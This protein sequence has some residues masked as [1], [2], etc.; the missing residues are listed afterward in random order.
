[1]IAEAMEKFKDMIQPSH[2]EIDGKNYR[3]NGYRPVDDGN[4]ESLGTCTLTSIV[5]YFNHNIDKLNTKKIYIHAASHGR[6]TLNGFVEGP[7]KIRPIFVESLALTNSFVFGNR[8]NYEQFIIALYSQFKPTEDR[9]YIAN[10]I[11]NLTSEASKTLKDNGMTQNVHAKA[12]ISM[13]EEVQ[14][15]NPVKLRPF[16]T[17]PEIEQPES[18]FVFRMEQSGDSIAFSLHEC[19]GS[20]WKLEAIQSIRAYFKDKLPDVPVIA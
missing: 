16:R 18:E 9:D 17:F 4:P 7:F 2:I 11:S 19:D 8:Y 12:G 6:V 10:L 13:K 20:A 15:K 5:D 3:L 1:M 14:V